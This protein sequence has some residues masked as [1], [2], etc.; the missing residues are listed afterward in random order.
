MNRT[1]PVLFSLLIITFPGLAL[2][3]SNKVESGILRAVPVAVG[4]GMAIS[5]VMLIVVGVKF[6]SGDPA[7]KDSAKSTLIG[8]VIILSASTIAGLLKTWFA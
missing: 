2:A 6:S 4:I 1:I 7:A 5:T 3:Q 8:A